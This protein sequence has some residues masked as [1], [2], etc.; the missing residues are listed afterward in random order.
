[1]VAATLDV[2]GGR[3]KLTCEVMP[4]LKRRLLRREVA[5][6]DLV[7]MKPEQLWPNG[8]WSRTLFKLREKEMA[9]EK[10]RAKEDDYNGLLKCGKCKSLKT[11]YT[12]M[13]TRSAD[14]PATVFASCRN[15]GNRWR[16]C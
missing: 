12:T 2:K 5:S 11:D 6:Q 13:Q 16:F 7:T 4:Q 1:V 15:C 9:M 10:M 14:E 3:V 8:P